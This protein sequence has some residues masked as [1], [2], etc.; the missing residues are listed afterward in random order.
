MIKKIR[1]GDK[2]R[3]IAADTTDYKKRNKENKDKDREK[4]NK[5]KGLDKD[6]DKFKKKGKDK[7]KSKCNNWNRGRK[8]K[9]DSLKKIGIEARRSKN[10]ENTEIS[11]LARSKNK[12]N[13]ISIKISTSK[14]LKKPKKT[15]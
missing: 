2:D 1:K 15:Q 8:R 7:S 13:L 9:V 12:D 10:K 3:C 6:K 4:K 11:L 5:N 14:A